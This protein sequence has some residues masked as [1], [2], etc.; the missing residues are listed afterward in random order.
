MDFI[1]KF[2]KKRGINSYDELNH[3]EKETY[4]R[5]LKVMSDKTLTVSDLKSYISTMKSSVASQLSDTPETDRDKNIHLKARL[6]NYSLLEDFLAGPEKAQK[7]LA[8]YLGDA[9]EFDNE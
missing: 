2:L 7:A 6:K 9:D 5:M 3:V 4:K 8:K 1:D